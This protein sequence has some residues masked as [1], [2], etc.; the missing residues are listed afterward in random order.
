MVALRESIQD[1]YGCALM[2]DL[3]R[4]KEEIEHE[5]RSNIAKGI[6]PVRHFLPI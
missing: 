3:A 5:R 2:T 4:F 6:E 1:I